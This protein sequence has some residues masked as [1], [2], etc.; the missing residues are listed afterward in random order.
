MTAFMLDL[1]TLEKPSPMALGGASNGEVLQSFTAKIEG[2]SSDIAADDDKGSATGIPF[3]NPITQLVSID[4]KIGELDIPP[5]RYSVTVNNPEDLQFADLPNGALNFRRRLQGAHDENRDLTRD[6][7]IDSIDDVDAWLGDAASRGIVSPEF[8]NGQR[9]V[10]RNSYRPGEGGGSVTTTDIMALLAEVLSQTA[11]NANQM[12]AEESKSSLA[13][14]QQSVQLSEKAAS[15]KV[16]AAGKQRAASEALA[17]GEMWS[18][19]A[20]LAGGFAQAGAGFFGKQALGQGLGQGIGAVGQLVE[21]G[22]KHAAAGYQYGAT[23][24]QAQADLVQSYS[25]QAGT[26]A[27]RTQSSAQ[28]QG[29]TLRSSLD[30]LTSIVSAINQTT[31]AMAQNVGR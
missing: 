23:L 3:R 26:M 29:Q 30:V 5:S 19:A 22:Y 7:A 13:G 14:L 17:T 24:D 25:Q 2:C 20:N 8:A 18:G 15:L 27:Q 1:A 9:A 10:L 11:Q 6:E 31:M 21:G 4:P 28:E 16:D 12:R